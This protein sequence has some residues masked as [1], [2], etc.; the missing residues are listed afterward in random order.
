MVQNR[1]A[2]DVIHWTE[3]EETNYRGKTMVKETELRNTVSFK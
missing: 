3:L 2:Y 1:Q